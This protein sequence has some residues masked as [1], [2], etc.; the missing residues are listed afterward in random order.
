VGRPIIVIADNASYHKSGPVQDYVRKESGEVVIE[1]L[2]RY[3]PELNPDE[4]VW[5]HAKNRLAKLFVSTKHEM[6]E[7]VG[8]I[9]RS[10]QSNVSLIKSFFLLA[11]TKY[12]VENV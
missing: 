10:I 12:I 11:D 3:A 7:A 1:H 9:L 4:Q 2:P 6:V 8:S 5:N